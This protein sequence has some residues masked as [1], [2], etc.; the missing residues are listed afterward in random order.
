MYSLS[1]RWKKPEEEYLK[2]K[3]HYLGTVQF[4]QV[5]RDI[6]VANMIAHEESSIKRRKSPIHYDAL[7][8]CLMKVTSEAAELSAG[9]HMPRIGCGAGGATWEKV[10]AVI[11]KTLGNLSVRVYDQ[12]R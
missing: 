3:K 9:I 4:V 10:E 6:W 7:Q 2:L 12:R 5:E 11:I 1:Q 8:T